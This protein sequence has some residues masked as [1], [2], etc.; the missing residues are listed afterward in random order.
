MLLVL[1]LLVLLA[2]I[3]VLYISVKGLEVSP[4]VLYGDSQVLITLS[5]TDWFILLLKIVDLS[6]VKFVL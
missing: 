4:Q 5:K 1:Q 3:V 6:C 2:F